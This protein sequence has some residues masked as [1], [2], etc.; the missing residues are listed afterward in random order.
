L[1]DGAAKYLS[2]VFNDEWLRENG[3]LEGRPGLGVVGD[4]LGRRERILFTADAGDR[5]RDVIAAMK[6]NGISQMPVMQAGELIGIVTEVALLR[7][8]ASGEYTLSTS[9]GPLA[10]GDYATVTPQTRI[11][12]LQN[13]LVDARMAIVLDGKKL[14]AVITK[15]DLIEYLA[16]K[17]GSGSIPPPPP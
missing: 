6:E 13:L 7:Y 17:H 9:V 16:K 11:E 4:L 1:P 10:E 12:L 2:K 14:L 3:F 15:I 5:V 8:L